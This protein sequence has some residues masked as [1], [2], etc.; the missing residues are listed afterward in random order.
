MKNSVFR[1]LGNTSKQIVN[2]KD[3]N[4]I[5][6]ETP[7]PVFELQNRV[8]Q[9]DDKD[10]IST[11]QTIEDN[12]IMATQL[13]VQEK[14][15]T[16]ISESNVENS[17]QESPNVQKSPDDKPSPNQNKMGKPRTWL[18]A[19]KKVQRVAEQDSTTSSIPDVYLP[20][21]PTPEVPASSSSQKPSVTKPSPRERSPPVTQHAQNPTPS[22]RSEE[23]RVKHSVYVRNIHASV[24]YHELKAAF[25]IYG[26]VVRVDN[27]ISKGYAFIEFD[28]LDSV[29][30]VLTLTTPISLH[31]VDLIIQE[32]HVNQSR[33]NGHKP[34]YHRRYDTNNVESTEGSQSLS[35][36]IRVDKEA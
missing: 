27:I 21:R 22:H 18:D 7:Q 29:Q 32:R 9:S 28:N 10:I 26:H 14:M 15:S 23:H 31:G 16:S 4:D 5:V 35:G 2:E 8:E 13:I 19:A 20:K 34:V 24:S 1:I 30:R 17:T 3:E 12:S 33:S 36:E 25:E 11:S 6:S